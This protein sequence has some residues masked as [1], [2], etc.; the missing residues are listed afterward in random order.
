MHVLQLAI[1][2]RLIMEEKR[3]EEVAGLESIRGDDTQDGSDDR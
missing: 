2:I 1:S 3:R